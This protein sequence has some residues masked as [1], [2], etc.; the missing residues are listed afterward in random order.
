MDLFNREIIGYV[1]GAKKDAN[2]VYQAFLNCKYSLYKISIFHTDRGSEF[3]NK[4]IEDVL[5]TFEITRSLSKKGCPYSNAVAESLYHVVK[6]EFMKK[7]KFDILESLE[8]G[9]FDYVNWYNNLRIHGSLDY[10]TPSE[11]RSAIATS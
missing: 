10:M 11:Y 2:L 7:R 4:L 6:T 1:A 9:L 8:T 5:K 3:K